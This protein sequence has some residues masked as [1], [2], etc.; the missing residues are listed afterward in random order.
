VVAAIRYTFA[1]TSKSYD[2]LLS[3]LLVDFLSLMVDE[4]LV[5]VTKTF[6]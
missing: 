6:R 1:D 3:P 2:Q 4:N 5:R